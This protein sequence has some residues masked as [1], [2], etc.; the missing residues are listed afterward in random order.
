MVSYSKGLITSKVLISDFF[1]DPKGRMF[2][3]L[4]QDFSDEVI[5]ER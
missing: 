4:I 3:M 2:M 5:D 1:N